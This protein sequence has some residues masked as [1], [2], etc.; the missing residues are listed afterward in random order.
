[1]S[2]QGSGYNSCALSTATQ[3]IKLFLTALSNPGACL[4]PSSKNILLGGQYRAPHLNLGLTLL[5]SRWA[6]PGLGPHVP[7]LYS[8]MLRGHHQWSQGKADAKTYPDRCK[9]PKEDSRVWPM[10]RQQLKERNGTTKS[11]RRELGL[12]GRGRVG[13]PEHDT[14]EKWSENSMTNAASRG[15]G[16]QRLPPASQNLTPNGGRELGKEQ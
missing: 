9:G 7:N 11:Q 16:H 4:K 6:I 14:T 8:A 3:L 5:E 13:W 10:G 1:M 12:W 2:L 15:S